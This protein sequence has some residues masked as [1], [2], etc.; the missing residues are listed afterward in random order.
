MKISKALVGKQVRLTWKDPRNV[1]LVS[2]FPQTHQDIQRGRQT[3]ATW[4][5]WGRVE[6]ITEGV[7]HLC[8]GL[9]V[10]PPLET[11]QQHELTLSIIPEELIEVVV[12]LLDSPEQPQ[13]G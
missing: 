3:L 9:A 4:T 7:V 5:E 1:H 2:K 10:D 13:G 12:V 8:Q 11:D 6:D